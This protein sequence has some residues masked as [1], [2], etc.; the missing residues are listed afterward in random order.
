MY[1]MKNRGYLL[2]LTAG[3]FCFYSINALAQCEELIWQE[4]FDGTSVDLTKWNIEV[5]NSGGGNGELQ[6]YTDRPENI[7]VADGLLTITAL[8]E[9]YLGSAYTSARINSKYKGDWKYGRFEARMKLPT[10]QGIW[11]AFWMLSTEGKYGDWPASGEIDIMEM[12]GNKPNDIYGTIHYGPVW[13]YL[14]GDTTI[15]NSN[16]FHIYSIEWGPSQIEWFVDGISFSV[17]KSTDVIDEGGVSR[18][19]EFQEKFYLIL[20]LAVGGNWPGA[21]DNTTVFPQKLVVDYVKVYGIVADQE[22]LALQPAYPN[23]KNVQYSISVIPN[24]TYNWSVP[25]GATITTGQGTNIIS[26]DWTCVSGNVSVEIG[27]IC[28]TSTI[29]KPIAFGTISITSDALVYEDQKNVVFSVPNLNSTTYTWTP[30]AGVTIVTGQGESSITADW[31][32]DI[33]TISVEINNTCNTVSSNKE[34][35]LLSPT[36]KGPSKVSENSKGVKYSIDSI[37]DYVYSWS[38]PVG[39]TII[40]GQ[41]TSKISVDFGTL[42]GDVTA[43]LTNTCGSINY[44]ISVAVTDTILL[45]DHESTKLDFKGWSGSTFEV[46]ANHK[47][48]ANNASPFIGKGYKTDSPWSGIYAQ[49]DHELDITTHK[50]FSVKI[51]GPKSGNI[52]L[53]LEKNINNSTVKSEEI[54]IPYTATNE[55]QEL[56]FDFSAKI[57]A[58]VNRITLFYDFNVATSNYFYFDDL[59]FLPLKTTSLSSNPFVF[60]EIEIYPIPAREK[61]HIKST[62]PTANI[63]SVRLITIAGNV[64]LTKKTNDTNS[65]ID[66]SDIAAGFYIIEVVTNKM[67][68]TRKILVE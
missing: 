46:M 13:K 11:P 56:K 55:W 12:V 39:A 19:Y 43:T 50:A 7:S 18:W 45:C 28:G 3:L 1:D 25:A 26:V 42:P 4:N 59:K 14:N 23:A 52:L 66:V 17:I 48:N 30:P 57:F 27:S 6:Y 44:P 61:L 16:D 62:N 51:L 53:K 54:A 9:N 68:I 40:S 35:A 29:T 33:G 58:G 22:I 60:S 15:T 10:G 21:P 8:K 32:C 31:G 2:M 5:S 41:A 36:I 38:V 47:T 67:I 24:A 34:I 49:L 20:N 37:A 65:V 63:E 64:V